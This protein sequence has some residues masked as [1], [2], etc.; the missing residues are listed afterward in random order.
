MG[1][2]LKLETALEDIVVAAFVAGKLQ[3]NDIKTPDRKIKQIHLWIEM[4]RTSLFKRN[5]KIEN[6]PFECLRDFETIRLLQV[7]LAYEQSMLPM[8]FASP[9]GE[10][11]LRSAY[12]QWRFCSVDTNEIIQ[13]PQW[14]FLFEFMNTNRFSIESK[15]V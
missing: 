2:S 3:A 9:K 11:D 10:R 6:L 1:V 5:I 13:D 4:V 12:S 14:S 7:S 8:F 15:L